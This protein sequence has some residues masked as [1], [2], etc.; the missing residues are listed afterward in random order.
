MIIRMVLF[1]IN[2]IGTVYFLG[3]AI[4]IRVCY[5]KHRAVCLDYIYGSNVFIAHAL[6]EYDLIIAGKT[7]KLK[8]WGDTAFGLRR[9][10][11]YKVFINKKDYTK[12][13]GYA[14]YVVRLFLGC[15]SGILLIV[16]LIF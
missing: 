1:L 15:F 11:Q 13:V 3:H 6:Y 16:D 14:D 7:V 9:G 12:V 5:T 4:Y 10:K 8:H 2:L